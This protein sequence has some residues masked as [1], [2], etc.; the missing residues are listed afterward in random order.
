MAR[1]EVDLESLDLRKLFVYGTG[2]FTVR[3]CHTTSTRTQQTSTQ[4]ATMA[5]YP[6]SVIKT[7]QMALDDAPRGLNGAWRTAARIVSTDGAAGLYR[8]IVPSLLGSI[9]ARVVYLSTLETVKA[10][11][12]PHVAGWRLGD[13]SSAFAINFI[14]GGTASLSSQAVVVPLDVVTQRLMLGQRGMHCGGQVPGGIGMVK[15]IL[16]CGIPF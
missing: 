16:R 1:R 10:V 12:T 4:A 15:L 8:G 6:L 9:P 2:M 13:A 7:Q 5:L 11:A 3:T 14:A